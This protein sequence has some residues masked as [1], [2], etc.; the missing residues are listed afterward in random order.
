MKYPEEC[1]SLSVLE[2]NQSFY[3]LERNLVTTRPTAS[4]YTRETEPFIQ[5]SNGIRR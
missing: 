3:G 5:T 4:F 2:E 1:E